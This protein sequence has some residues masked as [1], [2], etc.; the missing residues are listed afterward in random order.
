MDLYHNKEKRGRTPQ[1][2]SGKPDVSLIRVNNKPDV[3]LNRVNNKP[4]VRLNR[5]NNK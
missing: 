5:V 4:D 3:R 1:T 2:I